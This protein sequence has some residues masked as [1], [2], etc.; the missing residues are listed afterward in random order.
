M[1][2]TIRDVRDYTGIG[3]Q[4][5]KHGMRQANTDDPLIGAFYSDSSAC[6]VA[7]RGDRHRWN[8]KR[9]VARADETRPALD[10]LTGEET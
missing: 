8:L 1:K 5:I 6:A 10:N 4:E 9:A 7:V 2:Y 3:L